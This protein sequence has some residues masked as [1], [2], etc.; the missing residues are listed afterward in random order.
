MTVETAYQYLYGGALIVFL[1]LIGAM[2]IRSI[3][4]PRSTDRIMS[5]N[6]L[7]TMTISSIAILSFILKEE[8]LADVALIYAMISFVAVLMMASMF[9][10]AKPKK[11]RLD[12]ERKSGAAER[13]LLSNRTHAKAQALA[14]ELGS[15]AVTNEEIARRAN[16]IFLGVKPHM[17]K[18]VL[19][20]L[21]PI[22]QEKK[23]LLI[24]DKHFHFSLVY[25]I[26]FY[27][28]MKVKLTFVLR[29]FFIK[30]CV[31]GLSF[32]SEFCL[33]SFCLSVTI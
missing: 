10:P 8:Y 19:A 30:K 25:K 11:P 20:P 24:S 17:M 6:M 21:K 7:G 33:H 26:Q 5:V 1:I 31:V 29:P 15:T 9:I 14:E 28:G 32:D 3:I 13:I 16:L 2:V 12:A 27:L 18:D 22:L 23:P 4:G